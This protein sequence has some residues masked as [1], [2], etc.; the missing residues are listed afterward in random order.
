[1]SFEF[2]DRTTVSGGQSFPTDG[3]TGSLLL[4]FSLLLPWIL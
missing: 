3:L 4:N 2:L 1:M